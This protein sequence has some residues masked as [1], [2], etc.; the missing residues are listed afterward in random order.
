[1]NNTPVHGEEVH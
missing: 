1:M